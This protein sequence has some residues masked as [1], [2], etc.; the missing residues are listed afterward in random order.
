MEDCWGG[1][2][3]IGLRGGEGSGGLARGFLGMSERV[4]GRGRYP[5]SSR[6]E[7]DKCHFKEVFKIDEY[8][9]TVM[10]F[11]KLSEYIHSIALC[12]L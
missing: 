5:V 1:G 2:R 10:S 9:S 8:I 6:G 4:G 11:L 3:G 12:S 7:F